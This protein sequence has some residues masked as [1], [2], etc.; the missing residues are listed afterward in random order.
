MCGKV[1]HT[2]WSLQTLSSL[3]DFGL[4]CKWMITFLM[5]ACLYDFRFL[6]WFF[7]TV[8]N[9]SREIT[10]KDW[11]PKSKKNICNVFSNAG[12][13]LNYWPKNNY[14]FEN[15]VEEH[16]SVTTDLYNF[17]SFKQ[18]EWLT[19]LWI[20]NCLLNGESMLTM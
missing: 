15:K 3:L 5:A 20:R 6:K 4:R 16:L 19:L 8:C 9:I 10:H 1:K 17:N 7:L 2:I 11:L 14:N 13:D 18:L 12:E